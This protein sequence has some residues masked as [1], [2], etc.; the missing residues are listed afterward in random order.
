MG[1]QPLQ[2]GNEWFDPQAVG[3]GREE[4]RATFYAFESKQLALESA[5][6]RL[7]KRF[8]DLNGTW[9]FAWAPHLGELPSD[10]ADPTLDD[11]PWGDM[12]VPGNWELNGYGF[13]IYTNVI[14]VFES[15]PPWITYRGEDKQYNPTGAYRRYIDIPSEWVEQG[16]D[17]I[18]HIGA[19][20]SGCRAFLNGTELGFSTDS[21]LPTEFRLT[22]KVQPGRNLLALEVVCWGAGAYLE[23]QDMWWFAGITRDVYVYARPQQHIR[24]IEV[25]AFADG[26][27]EVDAQ[28]LSITGAALPPGANLHCE[29]YP[30]GRVGDFTA[31][32]VSFAVPLEYQKL[33]DNK[34]VVKHSCKVQGVDLWSAEVPNLYSLLVSF[35]L[36][37]GS[38]SECFCLNVGFRTV[39]IRD[40]RLMLNGHEL[41]IKGVNRHE[42]VQHTGH[43]VG[44]ESMLQ[45]ILLMKK[46]NFNAVRCAHYPNDPIFYDLCDEYGLYVVDEANI[47]SHGIDFAP[48]TTLGNKPE[49]GPS[50]M[51]RVQRYVER[52]KNYPCILFWS[53]GNEAGNGVNHHSTYKWVK[54]R[55][56]T[57]PCQYEH[58]R[59]EPGWSTEWLETIDSNTDIFCPMYPSQAKLGRYAKLVELPEDNEWKGRL[60][61]RVRPL[62]MVEY[63][64]AMGNT[65]GGFQEYW[66]VI[67]KHGI[68]QGGFIWDWVDQG[69]LKKTDE[70]REIWAYGGDYGGKGT[71]S[72]H[73]FCINGLVQPDRLPGPH[74][75]EAKQVQQ[76]VAFEGVVDGSAVE[77]GVALQVTGSQPILVQLRNRYDF[78]SLS[79]LEISWSVL[80]NGVVLKSGLFD[81]VTTGPH[82][83]SEPQA[84]PIYTDTLSGLL[85]PQVSPGDVEWH[86]NLS[87][88]WKNQKGPGCLEVGHEEAYAQIPLL[89]DELKQRTHAAQAPTSRPF[90]GEVSDDAGEVR[91]SSGDM[92]VGINKEKGVISGLSYR[93][94]ELLAAPLSPNFWRPVTDNDNGANLHK[95]MA[96][97]RHAGRDAVVVGGVN[98]ETC[99]NSVT[100]KAD[101]AVGFAGAVLSVAYTVGHSGVLVSADWK[102]PSEGATRALSGNAAFLLSKAANKHIHV[103]GSKVHAKWQSMGDWQ[104]LTISSPDVPAGEPLQDGLPVAL[105]AVTGKTEAELLVHGFQ[106]SEGPAPEGVPEGCQGAPVAATGSPAS[107]PRWILKRVAGPGEVAPQDEVYFVASDGSER[108]LACFLVKDHDPVVAAVKL[109][110]GVDEANTIFT[111]QVKDQ[112][113]PAKVG[114]KTTLRDNF[115]DVEWFGRGP[116]ESYCDRFSSTMVGR[117]QGAILDQTF[118]YVRPQE[119]GNKTDTRWMV[120]KRGEKSRRPGCSSLLVAAKEWPSG[121]GLNMQCHRY[122]MEEFD[123]PEDRLQQRIKHAGELTARPETDLCVDAAQ[124]GVG[125]IDSW[126][127]KPLPQHM[128]DSRKPLKWSFLLQPLSV[129]DEEKASCGSGNSLTYGVIARQSAL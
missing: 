2:E 107:Q 100:I 8:I 111:L 126:G 75:L 46:H 60:G 63:A 13:P 114:F 65:L 6:W 45:D 106:V 57:R 120:L 76:P 24:D 23:D 102:P 72:D 103:E 53:L 73:N 37:D 59:I 95:D 18:L 64:H 55:D 15:D 74:L 39:E 3:R 86:L 118:K 93:G 1:P 122:P 43:V 20:C 80:A 99:D 16:L 113:A 5:D 35:T 105:T 87:A 82:S 30:K 66:D 121:E 78:R 69:I 34:V 32:R 108:R 25:R 89:C 68:L 61:D 56:P 27:L 81:E 119:N 70:G 128:L 41:T 84:V 14:Y 112:P 52:D 83:V 101:L 11:A 28:I 17:I 123:M 116:H 36:A 117:Y 94:E 104:R 9:K 29:L 19:V 109:G 49:W 77:R 90:A 22:G 67:Y 91:I 21:K 12:P 98:V 4:P 47:E 85:P 124:M 127:N 54:Q 129:E 125:G 115:E 48:A 42:H 31:R 44:R 7:S 79:H 97:W 51:A 110:E 92:V 62:I 33:V 50:H 10:F 88:K 96:A 71:P 58:A 26:T 38:V 40:S